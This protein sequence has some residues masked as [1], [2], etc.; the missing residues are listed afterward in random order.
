MLVSWKMNNP[1]S[2][3]TKLD[4]SFYTWS[5]NKRTRYKKMW[6]KHQTTRDLPKL[7]EAILN[8]M[9]HLDRND[10]YY[11]QS[12]TLSTDFDS[13]CSSSN[14]PTLPT[15]WISSLSSFYKQSWYFNFDLYGKLYQWHTRYAILDQRTEYPIHQVHW[16]YLRNS[17]TCCLYF[18]RCPSLSQPPLLELL[19][20]LRN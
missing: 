19:L 17:R 4:A 20:Y 18:A 13:S 2:W 5:N 11:E 7:L 15:L 9:N 8:Y 14:Q 6:G 12:L 10:F 16:T 1:A 3:T